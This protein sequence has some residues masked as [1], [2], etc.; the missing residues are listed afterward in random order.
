MI[1]LPL[2]PFMEIAITFCR[3]FEHIHIYAYV[4]EHIHMHMYVNTYVYVY[5]T[6]YTDTH[7][8]KRN[9][10][11]PKSQHPTANISL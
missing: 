3:E 8:E 5:Y 7:T 4:C 10:L 11:N 2:P 9:P 1:F 6:M